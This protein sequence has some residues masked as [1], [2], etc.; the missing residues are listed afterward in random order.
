MFLNIDGNLIHYQKS[1]SGQP[2]ILL[3]GNGENLSIFKECTDMLQH[4]FTVFTVDMAGHGKSYRPNE[5]H[6][7]SQATDIYA[8]IQLLKIQKPLLYGFSDGG[9]VGLILA[10]KYPNLLSKLIVSGVNIHPYGLKTINRF[11]TRARYLVTK[12]KKA[13]L[14]LAEPH[15]SRKDLA[16]I[17]IPTFLTVGEHDCIRLAHTKFI[18]K[19]IKGCKLRVFKRH[20]HGSYVIHSQQI[21]KYILSIYQ[22]KT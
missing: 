20:L 3:H 15:I 12:S 13:W 17:K 6:Y 22:N 7:E 16:K 2:I 18:C 11:I 14:M 10:S 21:A 19:Y 9:I 1:G 5:L 4:F 8:F